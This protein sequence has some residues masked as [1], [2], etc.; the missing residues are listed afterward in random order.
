MI[1]AFAPYR[2][3]IR[4]F[5]DRIA[6]LDRFLRLHYFGFTSMLILLGAGLVRAKP[7]K[8][9][10]GGLLIVAA[11]FHVWS[12]VSNDVIDLDLDRTQPRRS[13][14]PL[15]T[16]LISK[17]A[18]LA[19]ALLQTPIAALAALHLVGFQP[20]TNPWAFVALG[21]GFALILLYNVWGKRLPFPPLADLTQ[22]LGWGSLAVFGALV[23]NPDHPQLWSRTATLIAFA[24]GY[25]LLISG[26]HGGLRDLITDQRHHRN[27]TALFF[28][29]RPAPAADGEQPVQST[30]TLAVYAFTIHT[31]IFLIG[32]VFLWR[33][34][35]AANE[36]ALFGGFREPIAW[37]G[38]AFLFVLSSVL[39]ARVVHLREPR[40]D[41]WMSLHAL[42]LLLPPLGLYV[43]SDVPDRVFTVVV[44]CCFFVPL[45]LQEDVL[46]GVIRF[47]YRDLRPF[48]PSRV[49][50]RDALESE[51]EWVRSCNLYD[52]AYWEGGFLGGLVPWRT[53]EGWRWRY[54]TANLGIMRSISEFWRLRAREAKPGA[55]SLIPT[56]ARA[57]LPPFYFVASMLFGWTTWGLTQRDLTPE[58]IDAVARLAPDEREKLARWI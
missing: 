41:H 18:A 33:P 1:F 22:G 35:E 7:E 9:T 56:I 25:I 8:G 20:G 15:V 48:V 49:S 54:A 39:L 3:A 34:P 52:L 27:T 5:C 28:G 50:G 31:A 14:D 13:K 32:F 17:E 43:I 19:L 53:A 24:V 46:P 47:L 37:A 38:T 11:C 2:M 40:R 42:V 21:S 57:I 58:M 6:T 44:G 30:R 36:P 10:V 16:G 29:A 23:T 12:Y 26:V 51:R 55:H 45:L 4:S